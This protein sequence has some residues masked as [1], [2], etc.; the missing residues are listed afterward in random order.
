MSCSNQNIFLLKVEP[1]K[2]YTG[3]WISMRQKTGL[4]TKAKKA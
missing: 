3:G 2:S 4:E 1:E